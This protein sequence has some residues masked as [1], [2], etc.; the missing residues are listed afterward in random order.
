MKLR[1]PMAGGEFFMAGCGDVFWVCSS[2]NWGT[3]KPKW[4]IV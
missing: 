1:H 4:L 2:K 3:P